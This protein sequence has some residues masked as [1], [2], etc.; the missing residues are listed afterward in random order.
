MPTVELTLPP[1][2]EPAKRRLAAAVADAF[3]AERIELEGMTV[4]FRHPSPEDV[5]LKGEFPFRRPFAR[6]AISAGGLDDVQK[7]RIAA[8]LGDALIEAGVAE[9]DITVAFRPIDPRGVFVGRGA[10]PW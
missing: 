5:A 9:V 8:R 7:Q 10:S 6:V 4:F 1:L 2:D 3:I